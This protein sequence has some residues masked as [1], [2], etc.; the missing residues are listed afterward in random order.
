MKDRMLDRERVTAL[1]VLRLSG[2]DFCERVEEQRH[3]MLSDRSN[4]LECTKKHACSS[5]GL[6]WA[7]QEHLKRSRAD[8]PLR[9]VRTS[10]RCARLGDSSPPNL[11][12][13]RTAFSVD[14][15][16]GGQ[17]IPGG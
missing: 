10:P 1:N 11:Q 7:F 15:H 5:N 13:S 2:A 12:V 8:Y 17:L 16:H 9:L 4:D 6:D 14:R 3:A